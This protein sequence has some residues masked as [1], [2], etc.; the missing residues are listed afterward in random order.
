MSDAPSAGTNLVTNGDFSQGTTLWGIVNGS[1][2]IAAANNELCV[3]VAANMGVTLGWPENSTDPPLMLPMS[4][5]YTFSYKARASMASVTVDAK[6]G[7]SV[8]PYTADFETAN[9]GV[10]TSLQPFTHPFT[11]TAG[12]T[13]TGIAFAFTSTVAQQVCFQSVSLVQN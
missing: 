13:S 1:A 9:D 5:S 2:M 3:T 11:A 10:T 7:H 6:V 8:S 12:D 4:A